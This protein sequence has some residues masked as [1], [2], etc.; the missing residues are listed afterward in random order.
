MSEQQLEALH[1]DRPWAGPETDRQTDRLLVRDFEITK[2]TLSDICPPTRTH[3]LILPKQLINWGLSTQIYEP[4]GT[5]LIQTTTISQ[6]KHRECIFQ[7]S[8][9]VRAS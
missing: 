5:I 8:Q 4:L 3:F 1:P 6:V 7:N 9:T 2:P